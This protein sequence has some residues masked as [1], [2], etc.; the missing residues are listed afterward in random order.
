MRGSTTE[1]LAYP[2][3][4][5]KR[6]LRH[7]MELGEAMAADPVNANLP[8]LALRVTTI[9]SPWYLRTCR[10]CK[11][12]F[13]EGDQ[14]RICPDC[15]NPYHDDEQYGLHCWQKC[16]GVKGHGDHVNTAGKLVSCC[17]YKWS[18]LLP[19]EP[20]QDR[21]T[22]EVQR[23]RLSPSELL[24]NQFVTGVERIWRPFG[25]QRVEKVQPGSVLAGR[26]CQWCRFRVRAGDWVVA[27]PCGCGA[28]F[29]QDVFR[30]LTCWNEWNGVEGNDYC[31]I[32]GRSYS[33]EDNER[34]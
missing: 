29:H 12:R 2:E 34:G 31:P 22:E 21:R 14:V 13:R 15:G 25:E 6:Q 24:V 7:E 27:C 32:T 10:V 11:N 26:Q 5:L 17:D 1:Q 18:G 9:Y 3:S 8:D 4:V 19:D 16:F 20:A 30:H 33:P 28:Y 23:P